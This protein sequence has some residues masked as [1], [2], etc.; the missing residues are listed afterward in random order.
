MTTSIAIDGPAGAGKSTIA[1]MLAEKMNFTYL[2]SGAMYRAVTLCALNKD[3]D[4]NNIEKLSELVKNLEIDVEYKNNEFKIY[5]DNNEI[6]NKIRSDKVDKNVS[7]IAQI[8]IIRDELVEKQR[9][10]ARQKNIVMDGRDIGT[11]VL[12]N[13]EYKFYITATVHERAVRRYQDIINRGE[14]NKDF[15]EVKDEI[16]RRDKIDSNRK[17]SP[18]KKAEDAIEIDTTNLNKKEVLTKILHIIKKGE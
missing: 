15:Q 2:D 10:I 14:N 17:Y 5:A 16:E 13:A 18:L 12:P 8:K 4:L 11:R 6:T 3:I 1:K 7:T 9:E